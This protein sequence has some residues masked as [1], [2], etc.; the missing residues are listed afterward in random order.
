MPQL[1]QEK[2]T[3]KHN[4]KTQQEIACGEYLVINSWKTHLKMLL[5]IATRYLDSGKN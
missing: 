5:E 1:L 2:V 3:L 4:L